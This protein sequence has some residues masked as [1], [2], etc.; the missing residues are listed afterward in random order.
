M[1]ISVIDECELIVWRAIQARLEQAVASLLAAHGDSATPELIELQHVLAELGR[2][3][4]GAKQSLA[5]Q[6]KR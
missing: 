6:E 3:P 5:A 4:F 1:S 2:F